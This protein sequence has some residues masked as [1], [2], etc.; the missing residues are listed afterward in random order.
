MT[1][2]S[3]AALLLAAMLLPWALLATAVFGEERAL[4]PQPPQCEALYHAAMAARDAANAVQD[5]P[6]ETR[7]PLDDQVIVA[8]RKW[9]KCVEVGT[10]TP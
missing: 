2:I 9:H 4:P 6:T 5:Q 8:L 3:R 1:G 7:L 10:H